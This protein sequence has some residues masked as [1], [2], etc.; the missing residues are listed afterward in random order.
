[1]FIEVPVVL[2]RMESSVFLFD[3]EE[4]SGLGGVRGTDFSGTKVFVKES[5]GG[6][7]FIK[8]ERV[9]FSNLGSERVGEVDFV[10]VGLRRGN[11]VRS[12]FSED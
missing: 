12:L 6:K 9:E 4:G 3:E 7:A 8:G 10:I 2:A 11:M 5:F 1:M